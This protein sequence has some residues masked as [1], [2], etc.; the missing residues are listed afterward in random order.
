[1]L[2][3]SESADWISAT[4]SEDVDLAN[5]KDENQNS[6]NYRDGKK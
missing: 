6:H 1:M 5:Y 4:C 2:T 3:W